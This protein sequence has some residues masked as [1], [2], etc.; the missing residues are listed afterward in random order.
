MQQRQGELV[1]MQTQLG[2]LAND[3]KA[4]TE[5]LAEYKYARGYFDARP[6]VLDCLREITLA[7]NDDERIWVTSLALHENGKGTLAG[8]AEDQKTILAL[9]GRLQKSRRFTDARTLQM[10]EVNVP[11]GR[12]KEQ[13]FTIGFTFLR[14]E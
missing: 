12:N 14:A 5:M 10:S 3:V 4:A 11:G 6:D 13:S 8:K 1:S 7:F 2:G 9:C